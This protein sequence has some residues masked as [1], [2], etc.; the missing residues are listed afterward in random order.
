MD[1]CAFVGVAP[2]GPSR[3]PLVDE[4][5]TIEKQCAEAGPVL[6][7]T[8]TVVRSFDEYTRLY[9]AF[10]GPGLLPY[11]VS[12]FFE[13]G[14][15]QAYIVRV[16]HNYTGNST[17]PD[18]R[19][20]EGAAA[21][22]IQGATASDP[23]IPLR[24]FARNEGT[25]GNQLQVTLGF[26]ASVLVVDEVVATGSQ[27]EALKVA[28]S[29]YVPEGTLLRFTLQKDATTVV[30]EFHI[31]SNSTLQPLPAGPGDQRVLILNTY[32]N[33]T[34]LSVDIVVA[35]L[36]VKDGAGNVEN[37]DNLGL[38]SIH[39]RWL[40][41]QLCKDSQLVWPDRAWTSLDMLPAS[42]RLLTVAPPPEQFQGGLDRYADVSLDDFFDDNWVPGDEDPGVQGVHCL[43]HLSDLSLLVVPDL[44]QPN[45]LVP[46]DANIFP[47][48]LAG[49]E[50]SS[51]VQVTSSTGTTS[52]TVQQ[53]VNDLPGL[54]LDPSLP[55][56]LA[57]IIT[58]QQRLVLL[59]E[60]LRSFIVLLDVPPRLHQR[61]I[62]SWRGQVRSQFVA[63]YHPWLDVS[64]T[65]DGR[66]EL[67]HINPAA[68]AAGIIAQQEN[69]FGVQYGPAN[70]IAVNVVS[71]DDDVSPARHDELHQNAIN[72]Y[73][74]DRE[75]IRLTAAR[76][77]SVDPSYRQL[78]V[79]RLMTMLE[80][81]LFQQ[82]QWMCFE[83]NDSRLRNKLRYL[84]RQLLRQ[85]FRASAFVGATENQA[86]FVRCDEVLN[87][88]LVVEQGQII[89]EVGV[90]PAEPLEF[91]VLRIVREGD[92]TLTV[93]S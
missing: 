37:Y 28:S 39:P 60:Q 63:A 62:L 70:A 32:P 20:S 49:S 53:P 26:R 58:Q 5:W 13:Q 15:Q 80:R 29:T 54:R 68:V 75:G 19:D 16:V 41:L 34:L 66:G 14:G 52:P 86:F 30:R 23:T 47:P 81:T 18:P 44:Y 71:L 77:L 2:R 11:A 4:V 38:S 67:I 43:V 91:L 3:V 40:A 31:V 12:S 72:V 50:F 46:Q 92:S 33:G 48:P 93:A 83:P 89:A 65:D 10:E 90:A 64:R 42:D 59:A 22:V 36:T 8:P 35:T 88:R 9:G 1:I 24:L 73:L 55:G 85:L 69:L 7:A 61:Q 45:P 74:R 82:C 79:R 21:G 51:C 6:L 57:L 17:T 78:N 27:I 56:D 84:V 87:N 25:W 76:T